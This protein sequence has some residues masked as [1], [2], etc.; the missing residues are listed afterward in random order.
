MVKRIVERMYVAMLSRVW[1]TGPDGDRT[2]MVIYWPARKVNS[3]PAESGD[4]VGI[5]STV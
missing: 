1:W 5:D 2:E 4:D 3:E